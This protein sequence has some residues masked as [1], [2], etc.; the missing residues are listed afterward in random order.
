MRVTRSLSRGLITLTS[1]FLRITI[2]TNIMPSFRRTS[3]RNERM[4]N[5]ATILQS[6][7]GNNSSCLNR[8]FSFLLV[9]SLKMNWQLIS[10]LYIATTL[11]KS[12]L[13]SVLLLWHFFPVWRCSVDW[14]PS[15]F[16]RPRGRTN[17]WFRFFLIVSHTKDNKEVTFRVIT[18]LI[19]SRI[20]VI[21]DLTTLTTGDFPFSSPFHVKRGMW[22]P[23]DPSTWHDS[24]FDLIVVTVVSD[25]QVWLYHNDIPP[26]PS[27]ISNDD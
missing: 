21:M 15:L 17:F 12:F 18:D 11:P 20:M 25:T 5:F 19:W 23:D 4:A 16:V 14:L 2:V 13:L 9:N 7:L 22:L 10:S 1:R 26:N 24:T 8:I 3:I 6:D 27:L